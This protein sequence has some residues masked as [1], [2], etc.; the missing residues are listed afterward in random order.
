V[1]IFDTQASDMFTTYAAR[2]RFRDRLMGGVPKNP[3]II[4]GWLRSKAGIEQE[5]EIRRALL[6]TLL[7]VGAEVTPDMTFE[8]LEKA[9]E[10]LAAQRQTNGFKIG[11]QG[12]YLESR[13]V[14]AMLKESVN[15]LYP[16]GS[17]KWGVRKTVDR[18]TGEEKDTGGKGAKSFVAERV[19]V[20]P[21][22]LW[23]GRTEPDGVEM[24]I[25]H[26]MGPKGPQS[27]LTY[28]EYVEGAVIDL[29]IMVLRDEVRAE[30]WPEIWVHAQENGLGALRSQGFGRFDIERWEKISQRAAA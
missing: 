17:G 14:K 22:R 4:E 6:R 29:E 19:F 11:E 1:G 26:V 8:E 13:T 7:E 30:Y 27:T 25:G 28:H 23:L 15:I 5:E 18:K 16:H 10:G 12:L 24:F 21:D 20:N 9:S 3:K 2:I